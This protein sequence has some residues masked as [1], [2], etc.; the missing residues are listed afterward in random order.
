M[1]ARQVGVFAVAMVATLAVG[2]LA[3]PQAATN[4]ATS[5]NFRARMS[6]SIG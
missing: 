1:R 4:A 6:T 5:R 2:A 3:E